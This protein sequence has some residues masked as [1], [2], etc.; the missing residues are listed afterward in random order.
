[1]C[2]GGQARHPRVVRRGVEC[3]QR[4]RDRRPDGGARQLRQAGLPRRPAR[5]HDRPRAFGID[6]RGVGEHGFLVGTHDDRGPGEVD[7]PPLLPGRSAARRSAGTRP[8]IARGRPGSPTSGS[9]AEARRR[10]ARPG[11]AQRCAVP[12]TSGSLTVRVHALG[13][14]GHMVDIEWQA[15]GEWT[16]IRYE[17][18]DG[19]AK[20]TI[21]RPEVRNA[22]RPLTT[23]ELIEAFDA[24]ARRPGD[25]R[26]HPDRR[27]A[28]R[29][30]LAA[31]TRR[32]VA[33]TATS[34]NR[35]S[36]GSTCSTSRSRSGGSRSR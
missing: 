21:D 19:I 20:I 9:P 25:R 30:Q 10:P 36:G 5:R 12:S 22:F 32:S 8:P 31:A 28:R 33:T 3:I 2:V 15:Q 35:G 27:R 4:R 14:D 1:M 34:T 16:D 17:T 24:G 11:L 6:R 23:R 29:L 26:G 18:A 13:V 7:Q